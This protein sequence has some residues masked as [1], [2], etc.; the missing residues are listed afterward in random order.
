M[1]ATS[2]TF[3]SGMVLLAAFA[4]GAWAQDTAAPV[5]HIYFRTLGVL[6]RE[7]GDLYYSTEQNDVAINADENI[8]SDFY[9]YKGPAVISFY[10]LKVNPD[11][12]VAH[13]NVANVD[14]TEKGAWPLLLLSKGEMPGALQQM[15]AVPDDLVA[16]PPG[17]YRF[18]N[19]SKSPC[20]CVFGTDAFV[21]APEEIKLLKPIADPAHRTILVQVTGGAPR[22]LIYTTN[23]ALRPG[24]RTMVFI[25][26]GAS[27][28]GVARRIIESPEVLAVEMKKVSRH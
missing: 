4:G 28:F 14:L 16:F 10:H 12:T 24:L 1:K 26:E 11:K 15:L 13:I 27:D 8:R 7:G 23:W 9:E 22:R 2:R 18:I 6:N 19:H 3:I 5:V 21:V 25:D 17:S 20:S